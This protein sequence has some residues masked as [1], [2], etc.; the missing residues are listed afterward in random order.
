MHTID[1][2]A[3]NLTFVQNF[4]DSGFMPLSNS[5]PITMDE[6]L[7]GQDVVRQKRNWVL[8][9]TPMPEEEQKLHGV[10]FMAFLKPND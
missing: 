6:I 10:L 3:R 7:V 9:D 2:A 1:H 4:I 8:H 5:Q